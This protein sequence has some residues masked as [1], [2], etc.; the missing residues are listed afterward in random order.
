MKGFAVALSTTPAEVLQGQPPTPL[1]QFARDYPMAAVFVCWTANVYLGGANVDS[2]GNG[3]L[4]NA[5]FPIALDV[6]GFGPQSGTEDD[7]W[8][9][10]AAGTATGYVLR[11]G[12]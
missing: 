3:F 9:V 12:S 4:L 5:G 6:L 2:A 7:L 1:I 10:L 11:R 8:A